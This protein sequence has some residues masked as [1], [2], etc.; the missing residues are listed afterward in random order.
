MYRDPATVEGCRPPTLPMLASAVF[1]NK[2]SSRPV[3]NVVEAPMMKSSLVKSRAKK[4]ATRAGLD[5]AFLKD[6]ADPWMMAFRWMIVC[7]MLLSDASKKSMVK[8]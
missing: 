7:E 1:C 5:N 3:E 8:V 2:R 4:T 6:Q